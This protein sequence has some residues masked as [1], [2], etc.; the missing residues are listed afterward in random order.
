MPTHLKTIG[1]PLLVENRVVTSG[2]QG[3]TRAKLSPVVSEMQ[4]KEEGK[5]LRCLM[6]LEEIIRTMVRVRC[7]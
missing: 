7:F 6:S 4:Y 5:K 3:F 1:T 2:M